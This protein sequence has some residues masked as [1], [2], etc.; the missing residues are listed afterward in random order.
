[1]QVSFLLKNLHLLLKNL[2]FL[3]KNLHFLSRVFAGGRQAA[4]LC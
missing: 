4:Q 2:H 1:M 3:L